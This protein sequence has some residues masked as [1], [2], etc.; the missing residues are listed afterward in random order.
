MAAAVESSL[1]LDQPDAAD[2][3]ADDA[4][5][6][7]ED[8]AVEQPAEDAPDAPAAP[9]PE[10]SEALIGSAA[11]QA[12]PSAQLKTAADKGALGAVQE[13]KAELS[14]NKVPSIK[15]RAAPSKAG[16][17]SKP[18]AATSSGGAAKPGQLKAQIS[19]K[20]NSSSKSGKGIG[21]A[22]PRATAAPPAKPYAPRVAPAKAATSE[23]GEEG[24]GKVAA[25]RS[26]SDRSSPARPERPWH[27]Y[28]KGGAVPTKEKVSTICA[29]KHALIRV[30]RN[31]Y[32]IF[33]LSNNHA[34]PAI[35]QFAEDCARFSIA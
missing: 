19:S 5:E 26:T 23:G 6:Q 16:L 18:A 35:H 32:G 7:P 3:Y 24:A 13:L 31:K 10:E 8:G 25:P 15:R 27:V 33:T 22:P 29:C 21:A 28:G 12:E 4:P 17:P 30:R 11:L 2:D 34:L 1:A 20:S 9:A 14:G